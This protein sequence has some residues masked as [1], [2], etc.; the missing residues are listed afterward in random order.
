MKSKRRNLS[1]LYVHH[2]SGHRNVGDIHDLHSDHLCECQIVLFWTL[3]FC[4]VK[5][6]YAS[7]VTHFNS[8]NHA[9]RLAALVLREWSKDR[10]NYLCKVVI[11]VA[12]F[13]STYPTSVENITLKYDFKP[14][15]NRKFNHMTIHRSLDVTLWTQWNGLR[16]INFT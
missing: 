9:M 14:S 3:W 10:F 5:E 7:Q 16:A 4:L 13:G 2:V 11:S 12:T 6:I 8:I 15:I 1:K